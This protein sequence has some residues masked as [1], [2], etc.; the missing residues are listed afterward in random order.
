MLISR[1]YPLELFQ[2]S[3]IITKSDFTF[4]IP[5]QSFTSKGFGYF[6]LV[7]EVQ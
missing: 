3:A 5:L 7:L 6:S 2:A 1:Y 4:Q